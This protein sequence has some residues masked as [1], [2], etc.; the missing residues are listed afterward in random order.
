VRC[1]VYQIP[2]AIVARRLYEV[3]GAPESGAD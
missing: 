3:A 1:M 2:E